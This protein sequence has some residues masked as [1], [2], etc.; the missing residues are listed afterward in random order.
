MDDLQL[1]LP[2]PQKSPHLS[3]ERFTES[4]NCLKK[5]RQIRVVKKWWSFKLQHQFYDLYIYYIY[6]HACLL[7][8]VDTFNNGF[9]CSTNTI[10]TEVPC[11]KNAESFGV[12]WLPNEG[13]HSS[14][15]RRSRF[16]TV[17]FGILAFF[18]FA[19]LRQGMESNTIKDQRDLPR[20]DGRQSWTNALD[21]C[22][23]QFE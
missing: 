10:P 11:Q 1:K 7:D 23:S 16:S 2:D 22:F 9:L 13:P 15:G 12:R 8:I 18:R 6:I 5:K 14:D 19:K 17:T 20:S 3:L 21:F 4:K